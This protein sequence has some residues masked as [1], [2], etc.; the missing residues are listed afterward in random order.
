MG[1]F[2]ANTQANHRSSNK[3]SGDGPK[4]SSYLHT[5]ANLYLISNLYAFP[6][7]NTDSHS[8]RSYRCR[9]IYSHALACANSY[10]NSRSNNRANTSAHRYYPFHA[11][12]GTRTGGNR[13]PATYG[14]SGA[15]HST[16]HFDSGSHYA[17]DTI[18]NSNHC[19]H[20]NPG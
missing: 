7:T 18:T 4:A 8:N 20:A 3:S 2:A 6:H 1:R 12:P 5:L 9:N 11:D 10:P 16:L 14:H 19:P 13:S 15:S 17:S